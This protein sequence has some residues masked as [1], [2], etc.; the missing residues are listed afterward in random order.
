MKNQ[1]Q[2]SILIPTV[3][4]RFAQAQKLIE[5]LLG[6]PRAENCEILWLGDNRA[7]TI[8]EKRDNLLRLAKGRYVAFCDDDDA[9]SG[10]YVPTLVEIAE[11]EAV[12]VISFQQSAVWNGQHSEVHFSIQNQNEPF[13]P[14]GI[15]K[16]FPWHV[17][18]WRREIAQEGVFQ[19]CQWGEDAAWVMQVAGLAQREA[20]VPRI[21]HYY[22]HGSGSLAH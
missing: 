6:Q 11:R 4:Q 10:D 12:D 21:L 14:G 15:T 9:V 5:N 7:R 16:R 2:L 20:H 19:H 3:P 8:G 22:E 17:C 1:P 18:A 13:N